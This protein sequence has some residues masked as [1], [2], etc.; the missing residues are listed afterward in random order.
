M[1]KKT[2]IHFLSKLFRAF[3]IF[4]ALA[5]ILFSIGV[6]IVFAGVFEEGTASPSF[7]ED[8]L[9][10]AAGLAITFSCFVAKNIWKITANITDSI[11]RASADSLH[12][13]KELKQLPR[14]FFISYGLGWVVTIS[15]AI[16]VGV[17]KETTSNSY[18]SEIGDYLI[19]MLLPNFS[20]VSAA[21]FGII[22]MLII[23]LIEQKCELSSQVELLEE[24]SKLTV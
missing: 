15:M 22:C 3:S 7:L 4:N 10:V 21:I 13:L 2:F 9:L 12:Y 1:V 11:G 18:V 20:G 14:L 17:T 6:A 23:K 5:S 16:S 24:E 19:D 8:S